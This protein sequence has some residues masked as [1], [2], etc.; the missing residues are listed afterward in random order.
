MAYKDL[1]VS[2]LNTSDILRLLDKFGVHENM[3][4]YVNN[5]LICPTICH[6]ELINNPSNKLY[7]YEDSKK[8]YCYTHCHAMDIYE[9]I[10]NV[11]AAR[12]MKIEFH[13]AYSLLDGIVHDRIEH[14]FAVIQEPKPR[15]PDKIDKNWPDEMTV[16]NHHVLEC[17][18][19]QPRYLAPWLSEGMDYDVLVQYGVK[20]DMI[21]NRMVFPIIDHLGRLVG[22]KV[23][24]FNQIDLDQGR[25][26]MPLYHNQELYSYPKNMVLYGFYQNKTD[27]K[28][29]KEVILF[30]AEKSVLLF[31]SYFTRNKS[32]AMCGSS[33]SVYQAMIL[34]QAKINKIILA[35]DND[36]DEDGNH[37]YG[38]DKAI[39][40]GI[41]IKNMG[42][43]VEI[44]YDWEQEFLGNKDAP[45]DKGRQIYSKL[46]RERKKIEDFME[47]NTQ[48][49]IQIEHA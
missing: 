39:K 21:R 47:E 16:Y 17:F 26:Y 19:Q 42:F 38:L 43:E 4:R 31:G 30:E 10:I 36:W 40:E 28:A 45:I 49:E 6:N 14:G 22:I 12:G 35:M 37:F 44:I 46:Y 8:F 33:F 48:N 13:Q 27:I 1:L 7:Y 32:V 18:T 25:K 41:K 9:F 11:Y 5:S 34:K 20:F 3:I 15:T 23:R 24:N 29:S 2:K